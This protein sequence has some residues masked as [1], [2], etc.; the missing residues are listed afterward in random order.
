MERVRMSTGEKAELWRRWRR[1]ESLSDIGRALGRI[2]R[3][4][5]HVVAAHGG[6]PPRARTRSRSALTLAE[7]EEIS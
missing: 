2:R 3:T 5:H 7:R 4:V 1:G 6:V